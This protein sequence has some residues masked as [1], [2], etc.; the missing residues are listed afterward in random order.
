MC[1]FIGSWSRLRV[2]DLAD[3]VADEWH[4]ELGERPDHRVARGERVRVAV[5][6]AGLLQAG[7]GHDAVMRERRHRALLAQMLEVRVRVLQQRSVG[8][9]I[10]LVEV[11]H[12]MYIPPLTPMTCPVM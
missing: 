10:D 3:V 4:R 8:E 11:S 6:V 7:D 1:S 2:D 12:Q 5:D 9:E